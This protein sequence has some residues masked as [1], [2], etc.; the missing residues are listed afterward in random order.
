MAKDVKKSERE[1]NDDQKQDMSLGRRTREQDEDERKDRERLRSEHRILT[2]EKIGELQTELSELKAK[3]AADITKLREEFSEKKAELEQQI[4]SGSAGYT[5]IPSGGM[6]TNE[7]LADG[8]S[9]RSIT[10]PLTA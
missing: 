5:A 10:I 6:P 1:D 2:P 3:F 7:T 8:S 9:R 4:G